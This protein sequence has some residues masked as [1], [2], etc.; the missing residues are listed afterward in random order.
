LGARGSH[1]QHEGASNGLDSYGHLKVMSV[2][3]WEA[4]HKYDVKIQAKKPSLQV[5]MCC[6]S[7]QVEVM[8]TRTH[9]MYPC[10][11]IAMSRFA[12]VAMPSSFHMVGCL[13][14]VLTHDQPT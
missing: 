6:P 3:T 14:H 12:F 1:H 11:S 8:E 4:W 5:G 9:L 13:C 7:S 10:S 2:G